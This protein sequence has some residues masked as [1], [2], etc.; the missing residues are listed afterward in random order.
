MLNKGFYMKM[1]SFLT[2][3]AILTLNSCAYFKGS[4]CKKDKA[5]CSK[6]KCEKEKD[7]KGDSCK[8]EEVP[9]CHKK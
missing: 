5:S 2:L 4:C 6:E 3:T 9:S 8:K 7:C 1:M